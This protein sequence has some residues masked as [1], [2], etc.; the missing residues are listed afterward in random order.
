MGEAKNIN[1]QNCFFC[2]NCGFL[3]EIRE[4]FSAV[5]N[6]EIMKKKNSTKKN[7]SILLKYIL[8]KGKTE[9]MP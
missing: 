3:G 4:F 7:V 6:F 9:K 1:S 8:P 5:E 2:P